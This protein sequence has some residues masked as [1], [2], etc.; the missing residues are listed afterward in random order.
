MLSTTLASA[1]FGARSRPVPQG[2]A[3]GEAC[4]AAWLPQC[5]APLQINLRFPCR[6]T[7]F[8]TRPD[9]QQQAVDEASPDLPRLANLARA[10]AGEVCFLIGNEASMQGGIGMTEEYGTGSFL[11]R[12]QVAQALSGY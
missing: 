8:R 4:R 12:V 1:R 9:V 11:R 10:Q 3:S 5:A 2:S 6:S 7:A